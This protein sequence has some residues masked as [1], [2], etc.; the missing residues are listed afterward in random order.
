M[1]RIV[2]EFGVG[3]AGGFAATATSIVCVVVVAKR[4]L[5]GFKMPGI[6]SS[7]PRK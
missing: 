7:P 1:T 6:T 4:K 3:F 5:A 2:V